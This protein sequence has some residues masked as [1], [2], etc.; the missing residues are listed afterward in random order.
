VG[1]GRAELP[2]EKELKSVFLSGKKGFVSFGLTHLESE[3]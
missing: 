2:D 1:W 3:F